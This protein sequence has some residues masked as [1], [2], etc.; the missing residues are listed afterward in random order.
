MTPGVRLQ[1]VHQGTVV[2][3]AGMLAATLGFAFVGKIFDV[4]HVQ[5]KVVAD[6]NLSVVH[7][8]AGGLV[9]R[10]FASVGD[11]LEKDAPLLLLDPNMSPEKLADTESRLNTQQ[12]EKSQLEKNL[13]VVQQLV[14]A[15]ETL[16]T[17]SLS[18]LGATGETF[19]LLNEAVTAR[20]EMETAAES[21]RINAAHQR[22]QTS[23]E[24]AMVQRNIELLK[25]NLEVARRDF[26]TREETVAFKRRDFE[27]LMKLAE[28]G[29]VS[30]ADVNRDRDSLLAAETAFSDTRKSVDQIELDISNRNLSTGQ[31]RMQ[32]ETNAEEA[33]N[34]YNGAKLRFDLRLAR[35]KEH[36][37]V[38]ER[39]VTYAQ[40]NLTSMKSAL[41]T[42]GDGGPGLII[43]TP[44]AGT[45]VRLRYVST[46]DNV[47]PGSHV[48]TLLPDGVAAVVLARLP[49]RDVGRVHEGQ[50]ARIKVDAYPYAQFGTI[51]ATVMRVFAEPDSPEFTA[52]LLLSR[53]SIDV[54]GTAMPLLPGMRT[55]V[56]VFTEERRLIDLLV[57][58]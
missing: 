36:K 50:K 47:T 16:R 25:R 1:R 41:K 14:A 17:A 12:D 34:R 11:H 24:L 13:A 37:V 55:Q 2:L 7:A 8:N 39:Q 52:K 18:T 20:Q 26:K 30:T 44:V 53:P 57:Y 49:H 33:N 40:Q 27:A 48:A 42:A 35:L 54:M 43:R 56:E 31:L 45:L 29:L 23:S 22:E 6:H 15:P 9:T 38:L 5:G 19:N 4:V 51:G 10:V 58:P 46:G 32:N 28:K 21:R 3:A